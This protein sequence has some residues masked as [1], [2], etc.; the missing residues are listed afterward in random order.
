MG[1][2]LKRIKLYYVYK[3]ITEDETSDLGSLKKRF[4]PWNNIHIY[5]VHYNESTTDK[6]TNLRAICRKPEDF[7]AYLDTYKCKVID[8][9]TICNF[10]GR[11]YLRYTIEGPRKEKIEVNKSVYDKLE[12][13]ENINEVLSEFYHKKIRLEEYIVNNEK[14]Y[15][16]KDTEPISYVPDKYATD[17]DEIRNTASPYCR[18]NY[19]LFASEIEHGKPYSQ[20]CKRVYIYDEQG[21]EVVAIYTVVVSKD[22]MEI[23]AKKPYTNYREKINKEKK[24]NYVQW[25]KNRQ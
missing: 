23:I 25:I 24:N 20:E 5:S 6:P 11:D 17:F 4:T 13:V 1:E 14:N 2:R 8:E 16:N 9:E 12:K 21:Y 10:E 15:L 3:L 22:D 7:N 19:P 18:G